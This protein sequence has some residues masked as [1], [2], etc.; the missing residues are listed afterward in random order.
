MKD[1]YLV[2]LDIFPTRTTQFADVVL[3]A[4]F[5]Y[6][7]GGVYGCSERRSQLTP[8]CVEPP[9]EA[10]PDL[11]IA[12]QIAKRMGLE[13]LIPWN[14]GDPEEAYAM[15][16]DD[17]RECVKNT[18]HTLYGMTRER[19]AELDGGLQWP[20]PDRRARAPRGGMCG[21]RT[22]SWTCPTS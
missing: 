5:I 13:K 10:K 7:K 19:L 16:W 8:K 20:C 2:V 12:A 17:Y 9:G 3:P 14:M 4:A 1:A 18:E 21:A 22:R 6:E 11:W 15:A